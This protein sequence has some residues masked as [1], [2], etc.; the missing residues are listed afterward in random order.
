MTK[1][2]RKQKK[3]LQMRNKRLIKKYYFLMPTDWRGKPYKDYDY[4][5]TMW[6]CCMGWDKAY[7]DM[8]LKELGDAVLESGQK[9]FTIFQIKE[10]YGSHRVYVSGTTAKVHDIINKYELISQGVCY[11]C[12]KPDVP[13]VGTFWIEPECYE[14]FKKRVKRD[15]DTEESI[16]KRY[17][18]EI[19]NKKDKDGEYKLPDSF[20]VR[21]FGTGKDC[22]EVID[23]SDTVNKI[24]RRYEKLQM[25]RRSKGKN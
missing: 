21:H 20:T 18:E 10:K 13:I 11:S 5:Y 15:G 16:R 7:G 22:D 23:I 6:G 3:K 14:C 4:T 9:D 25:K 1:K 2:E 8:Y 24:R 19:C 17:E 12:G